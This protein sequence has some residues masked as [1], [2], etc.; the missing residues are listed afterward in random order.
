M[1][2]GEWNKKEKAA[3]PVGPPDTM[4]SSLRQGKMKE[5][6]L[7]QPNCLLVSPLP[8]EGR[9]TEGLSLGVPVPHLVSQRDQ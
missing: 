2:V 9:V 4:H 5:K 3:S 6:K 8:H 1:C 7:L